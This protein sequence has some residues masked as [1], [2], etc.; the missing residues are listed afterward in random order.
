MSLRVRPLSV[1]A[2]LTLF[3]VGAMLL[4]LGVY[5]AVVFAFV[6]RSLINSLDQRLRGDFW[7]TAAMVDEGPDGRIT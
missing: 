6:S 2:W 1:R 7:L 5:A 4:V 3:Y